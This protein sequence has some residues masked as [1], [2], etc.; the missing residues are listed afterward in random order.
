MKRL[1]IIQTAACAALLCAALSPR[2]VRADEWDK[3]TIMNFSDTVQMPGAT[4]P[5]G[6][7]VFK[8]VE[9]SSNRYVVQVLNERE[10]HVFTTVIAI[11]DYRLEPRGKTVVS[12]YEAPAGQPL[13]VKAWFY[14]GDNYGREFVYSKSEAAL[15]AKVKEQKVRSD[16]TAVVAENITPTPAVET[17]QEVAAVATEPQVEAAKTPE[18][19][20]A[21]EPEPLPQPQESP[22]V[23]TAEVTETPTDATPA[24]EPESM[25]ATGSEL[26]LV[27]LIGL[28]SIAAAAAIRSA[29]RAS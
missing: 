27:M 1:S 8:V 28:S 18:P 7:Y 14:P 24:P 19:V 5:A 23:T 16:E 21:A 26:P 15:I 13:P 17:T 12:F 3:K 6:K 25:P 4:L 2:V 29:R 10:N 9:S 20:V 22:A 11:P